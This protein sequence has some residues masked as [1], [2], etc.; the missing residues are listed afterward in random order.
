MSKKKL[1]KIKISVSDFREIN[2]ELSDGKLN[3]AEMG[4]TLEVDGVKV[5]TIRLT[6][7]CG[8][9]FDL[10][11]QHLIRFAKALVKYLR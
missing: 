5:Q 10:P 4:P 9:Y 11:T 6:D 2:M 3:A 1:K 8:N 7:P